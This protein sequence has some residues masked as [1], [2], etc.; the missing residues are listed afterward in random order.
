M[1]IVIAKP[2]N[3][4]KKDALK[5]VL[6]ALDISFEETDQFGNYNLDFVAKILAGDQAKAEGKG[7]T[8]DIDSMWK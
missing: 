8:I 2:E 5:A 7:V 3:Q 1:S 6:K 4:A